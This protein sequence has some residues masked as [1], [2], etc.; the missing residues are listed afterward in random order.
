[1]FSL[2]HSFFIFFL[3]YQGFL[4]SWMKIRNMIFEILEKLIDTD[5]FTRIIFSGHS[6]GAAYA[7]L[8]ELFLFFT[9]PF[10]FV[11]LCFHFFCIFVF[12]LARIESFIV[13]YKDK[14][15]T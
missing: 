10:S 11:L 4:A 2:S 15:L 9:S 13:C 8:G 7:I 3:L 5:R 12:N 14:L 1:M 6:L